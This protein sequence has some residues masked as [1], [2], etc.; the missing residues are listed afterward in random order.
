M[1]AFTQQANTC[2]QHYVALA[3]SLSL[4][5]TL[6][7]QAEPQALAKQLALREQDI[8]HHTQTLDELKTANE[9]RAQQIHTLRNTQDRLH[10]LQQQESKLQTQIS[11]LNQQAA[12]WQERLQSLDQ[13]YQVHEESLQARTA[14]LQVQF[15]NDS[16]QQSLQE[17]GEAAFY[18]QLEQNVQQYRQDQQTLAE[19]KQQH[20]EL[21]PRIAVTQEALGNIHIR[22]QQKHS[23]IQTLAEQIQTLRQR[24][25]ALIA[26]Q[27]LA[28]LELK[29]QQ[30][31]KVAQ[32]DKAA[33]Q[34]AQHDAERELAAIKAA[35]QSM[36]QQ[37][38][39]STSELEA[40]QG[41]WT[42][43]QHK[44]SLDE[45][46]L[47]DLLT[48]D[49]D[50]L[51]QERAALKA[52]EQTAAATQLA[53]AE[54]QQDLLAQEALA[55]SSNAWL[56]QHEITDNT[57]QQSQLA[58]DWQQQKDTLDEQIFQ[59][60]Q[61]LSADEQAKTKAGSLTQQLATQQGCYE[62]WEKM[63]ELIGSANGNKFR[64]LAQ[65]LTL[66]QLVILANE[67][68]HDLAPRYALQPVPGNGLALQVVDHD[69][70]DEVRS[71]ESL[72]GGES[73]LVS[74][75]LALGLASLATDTRQLGSLFIDEGFGT[76]DPDSLEMALACLDALQAEGRQIGVISHVGT[77]V[78]RIGVQVKVEAMG[79]GCSR[80]VVTN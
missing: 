54:R 80:V 22:L 5:D 25:E 10:Q 52:I 55:K 24:R 31:I 70:G 18:T 47:S 8:S 26:E 33:A 2:H 71:V 38:V 69:M 46:Q 29:H 49:E 65:S 3:E 74:L 13:Q 1:E 77:L 19:L 64:S 61:R 62:L 60:R 20:T 75:A 16:W 34:T 53:L 28:Q 15:G 58:T 9:Q 32:Q 76:L 40:T 11:T 21:A 79:G 37:M 73:F 67:H 56:A 39:E 68:L 78:E 63:N 14:A 30:A 57:E 12:Q 66:Q 23:K 44:L 59:C 51:A 48:P 35:L 41:R 17:V 45:T 43:W 42:N 72:S 50:W 7:A 4:A 6:Q 27:D 36:Q